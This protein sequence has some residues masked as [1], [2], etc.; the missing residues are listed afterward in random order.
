MN[1]EKIERIRLTSV[2]L[3]RILPLKHFLKSRAFPRDNIR[4][5]IECPSKGLDCQSTNTERLPRKPY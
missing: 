4:V 1:Y 3:R 5:V 2:R